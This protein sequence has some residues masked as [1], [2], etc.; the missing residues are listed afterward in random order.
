MPSQ[1]AAPIGGTAII[2]A[3]ATEQWVGLYDC[4]LAGGRFRRSALKRVGIDAVLNR[5]PEVSRG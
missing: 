3:S 4:R 1:Q 2:T 5:S